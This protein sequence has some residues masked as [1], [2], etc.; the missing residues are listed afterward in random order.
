MNLKGYRI[1]HLSQA[2]TWWLPPLCKESGS[3]SLP[4]CFLTPT[5][6]Q[7]LSAAPHPLI[8]VVRPFQGPMPCAPA[9]PWAPFGSEQT[10]PCQ[11]ADRADHGCDPNTHTLV[12]EAGTRPLPLHMP[13]T[14]LCI[15]YLHLH[16]P[17]SLAEGTPLNAC[18]SGLLQGPNL[19]LWQIPMVCLLL[20]TDPYVWKHL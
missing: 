13:H 20:T 16:P 8:N 1:C 5:Q 14:Q 6:T 10:G 12:S 9:A 3:V 18:G 19:F 7:R 17:P 2:L 4:F 11:S 15:V